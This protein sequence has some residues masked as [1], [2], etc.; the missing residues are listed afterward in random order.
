[1]NEQAKK[2][3]HIAA[4]LFVSLFLLW[5]SGYNT[6]GVFFPPLLKEFHGT[7]AS[8]SLCATAIV[9]FTGAA[10]P[11]AGWLIKIVDVRLV[12][13]AG[14]TLAGLGLY[15]I[16]QTASFNH[17]L[18]WY[19]LLG[20]GLG[21]ST[22]VPAS[23]ILT[24]WFQERRGTVL[25]VATA[26]MELGGMIMTLLSARLIS[27]EG[28]RTAYLVL[29]APVF[30]IVLPLI[31]LIVRGYPE[32]FK[33]EGVQEKTEI[34]SPGSIIKSE[35]GLEVREA[36][37]TRSF[38]LLAIAQFCF[39]LGVAGALI[40]LVPL[41]LKAKYAAASAALALS[42]VHA[43][44]TVGKPTMGAVGDHIGARKAL[45]AG[46][47]LCALGVVLMGNAGRMP[48]LLLGIGF[49][50]FMLA[51]PIALVPVILLEIAGPRSLGTLFGLLFFVQTIGAAIGPIIVGWIFDFT[52]SYLTGYTFSAVI[53][54]GAA[55][56]ILGCVEVYSPAIPAM[57][58]AG[59]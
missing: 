40:H 53:L 36:F 4:A 9:L 20:V 45:A 8:I 41:M 22:M 18:A 26:G 15:G 6:F 17:L 55:I 23:I 31:I 7:H 29:A 59:D 57:M 1:M 12:M 28:W 43:L 47:A 25:G 13:G 54:A 21:G 48:L 46:F 14:A 56:S 44:I 49:Y 38:W 52:G 39:G 51:T 24:N 5:G 50:A 35:P 58:P 2:A 19:V 33:A 30:F 42:S 11:I 37:H 32:Q 10:A 34:S 16:S 27:T 3:R